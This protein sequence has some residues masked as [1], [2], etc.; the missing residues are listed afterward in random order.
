[1]YFWIAPYVLHILP[2][3]HLDLRFL[4][5]LGEEYNACS[6][7]LC[8]FLYS[9]VILSLLVPNIFLSNT[10]FSNTLNLCSSLN[11]RDQVSQ[12]GN[13]TGYIIV[14]YVLTSTFL[15][16]RRDDKFSQ[17]N[18]NMHFRYLNFSTFL[19]DKFPNILFWFCTTTNGMK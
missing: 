7:A 9:P 16:I 14:L 18:N 8:N 5:M 15:E 1:M 3:S 12:P 4:I 17:V 19:N 6:A 11:V 13:T 2:I 10:L